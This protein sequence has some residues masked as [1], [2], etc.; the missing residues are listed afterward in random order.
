MNESFKTKRF[1]CCLLLM[2][3]RRTCA[4]TACLSACKCRAFRACRTTRHFTTFFLCKNSWD[5]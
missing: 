1:H 5:K 2:S 4:Y 3:E